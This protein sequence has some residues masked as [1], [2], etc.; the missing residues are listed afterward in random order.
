MVVTCIRL[1]NSVVRTLSPLMAREYYEH[2]PFVS[3]GLAPVAAVAAIL[4]IAAPQEDEL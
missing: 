4:G 1:S 2:Q 3:Q